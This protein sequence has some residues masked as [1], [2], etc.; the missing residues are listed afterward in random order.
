M[1][2]GNSF[3]YE[4]NFKEA[5]RAVRGGKTG[6]RGRERSEGNHAV[7]KHKDPSDNRHY[8]NNSRKEQRF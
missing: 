7:T 5:A 8:A 3:S 6:P 1:W 2:P 4:K